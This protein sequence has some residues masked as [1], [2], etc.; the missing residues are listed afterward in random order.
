MFLEVSEILEGSFVSCSEIVG[1]RFLI[2]NGRKSAE[3][4]LET[5]PSAHYPLSRVQV[6][7]VSDC[8]CQTSAT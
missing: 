5:L 4:F 2:Q 6:S 8:A 7:T 3:K 1:I